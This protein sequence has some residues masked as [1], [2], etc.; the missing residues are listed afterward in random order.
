M[1]RPYH[2][3][4]LQCRD[5]TRIAEMAQPRSFARRHCAELGGFGRNLDAT[6]ARW[7]PKSD[8]RAGLAAATRRLI[9]VPVFK[10]AVAVKATRGFESH[11]RRST[12]PTTAWL[13]RIRDAVVFS[14]SHA[15]GPA[16]IADRPPRRHAGHRP[17]IVGRSHCNRWPAQEQLRRQHEALTPSD[18]CAIVEDA[19]RGGHRVGGH[20][21][22]DGSRGRADPRKRASKLTEAK[23]VV[24]L[25]NGRGG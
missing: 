13:G 11:P 1:T 8:C 19:E 6:L 5:P 22:R 23:R 2:G 18:I 20:E 15:G 21:R 24:L 14:T 17:T 16:K 25:A 10:P 7:Q 3:N 12:P 9:R 4:Q